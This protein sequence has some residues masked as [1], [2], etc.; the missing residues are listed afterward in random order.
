MII[1]VNDRPLNLYQVFYY[2]TRDE[3]KDDGS[4]S[5][6]LCFRLTDGRIIIEEFD[7]EEARTSKIETDLETA[8]LGGLKQTDTYSDLPEK[9]SQGAIYIV[10]DTGQTY[11]WDTETETYIKTG[12]AGRTGVYATH[13]S[14]APNIGGRV[15]LDKTY[16]QEVVPASVDFM[17]GSDIIGPRFIHGIIASSTDTTIT[18]QT[19]TDFVFENFLR[20]PTLQDLPQ[21]SHALVEELYYV[22]DIGEFRVLAQTKDSWVRPYQSVFTALNN[23]ADDI[24]TT[25][26]LIATTRAEILNYVNTLITN[27]Y[28][29]S[30]IDTT[31]TNYYTKSE[32]NTTLNDYYTKSETDSAISTAVDNIQRATSQQ[33]QALF[34]GGE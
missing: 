12:T 26:Q 6:N 16:F 3:Q 31:L 28:T 20:V 11:Y 7:S 5:Y 13:E 4:T 2:Y 10:K 22:E 8:S 21:V 14:L 32:I 30:E 33:I 18:V 23:L 27:Y 9:G 19:V 17:D 15:T 34:G 29:K 1:D 25:N 24:Q